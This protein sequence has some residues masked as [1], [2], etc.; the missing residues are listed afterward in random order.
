MRVTNGAHFG[1]MFTDNVAVDSFKSWSILLKHEFMEFLWYF[2]GVSRWQ[3]TI[4]RAHIL[5]IHVIDAMN[6]ILCWNTFFL[7]MVSTFYKKW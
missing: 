5:G 2:I 6:C 4:E 3:T 1:G 7:D